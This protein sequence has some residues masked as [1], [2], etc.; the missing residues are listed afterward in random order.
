MVLGYAELLR[1]SRK[2]TLE[3]DFQGFEPLIERAAAGQGSLVLTGH[4]GAWELIALA[5]AREL[6]LPITLIVRRPTSASAERMMERLRCSAGLEMLPPEGSFFAASRALAAGRVVV[7]LLDQRHN[8]GIAVPFFG[9]PALTSKGLALLA[10]RSGLPVFGA[11]AFREGVGRHRF[12]LSEPFSLQG[13]VQA[14]TALFMAF[15]EARI[16]ER[17]AHWLWLHARWRQPEAAP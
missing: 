13:E 14:D 12:V 7:F 2:A 10:K 3:F 4:G 9:R 1:E 8:Q 6:R 17:P 15:T 11:W 16:R 5:S